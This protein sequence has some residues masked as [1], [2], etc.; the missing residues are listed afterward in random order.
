MCLLQRRFQDKRSDRR[1]V[2]RCHSAIELCCCSTDGREVTEVKWNYL[3][4]ILIFGL[5]EDLHYEEL[6]NANKP[7][8]ALAYGDVRD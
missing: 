8:F 7:L 4:S 1:S 5:G 6:R 3:V 2:A